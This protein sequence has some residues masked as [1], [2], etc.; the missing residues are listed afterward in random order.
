MCLPLP[1]TFIVGSQHTHLFISIHTVLSSQY[2]TDRGITV[3]DQSSDSTGDRYGVSR[4]HLV[5]DFPLSNRNF[6]KYMN[7]CA[8]MQSYECHSRL[9]FL[10]LF[11]QEQSKYF[12]TCQTFKHQLQGLT[13]LEA[14]QQTEKSS[15]FLIISFR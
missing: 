13:L 9:Q 12:P 6:Q 3:K 8:G 7:C 2:S 11:A 14:S 1:D 5:W 4:A 10:S 15:L